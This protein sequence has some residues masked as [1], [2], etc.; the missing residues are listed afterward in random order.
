MNTIKHTNTKE[1]LVKNFSLSDET[2]KRI[3]K[4][5]RLKINHF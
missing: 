2:K 4:G 1:K 5:F 3:D